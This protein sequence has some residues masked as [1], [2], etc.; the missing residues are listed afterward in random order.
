MTSGEATLRNPPCPTAK[1]WN[2]E[3]IRAERNEL[4]HQRMI[5]ANKLAVCP[6]CG[7]EVQASQ[8]IILAHDIPTGRWLTPNTGDGTSEME[9]RPCPG[10][11]IRIPTPDRQLP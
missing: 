9:T 2:V 7:K 5:D 11:G 3:D 10:V 8:D 6:C 1:L 4:E